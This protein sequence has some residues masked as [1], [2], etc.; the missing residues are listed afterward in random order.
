MKGFTFGFIDNALVALSALLGGH[1]DQYFSGYFLNGTLYGA[2][3]GHTIGDVISGY[4][5]FDARVALN[6]GLGCLTVIFLVFLYHLTLE[7]IQ[8]K[9]S[10]RSI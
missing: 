10:S 8:E 5:E 9:K 6:M 2:L 3:I 7:I 1:I 4:A